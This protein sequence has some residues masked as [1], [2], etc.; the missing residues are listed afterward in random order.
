MMPT[1][2]KLVDVGPRDGLQNEAQPIGT[3]ALETFRVAAGVP[4]YGVDITEKHIPQER[5]DKLKHLLGLLLVRSQF[6]SSGEKGGYIV[7]G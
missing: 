1:E 7:Q 3:D 4:R 6:L 2:V 5:G